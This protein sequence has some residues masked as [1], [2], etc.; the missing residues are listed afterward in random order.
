[1]KIVPEGIRSLKS[2]K[3]IKFDLPTTD[4]KYRK[5]TTLSGEE[6]NSPF[7]RRNLPKKSS[8]LNNFDM[9]H[10]EK[11]SDFNKSLMKIQNSDSKK[12]FEDKRKSLNLDFPLKK[13]ENK[14]YLKYGTLSKAKIQTEENR[15]RDNNS[16]LIKLHSSILNKKKSKFFNDDNKKKKMSID[17]SC[18]SDSDLEEKNLRE[19]LK[20]KETLRK[21][22]SRVNTRRLSNLTTTEEEQKFTRVYFFLIFLQYKFYN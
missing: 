12:N 15:K 21:T 9:I 19:G 18:D 10:F 17:N 4:I 8:T 6:K 16:N 11:I 5:N 3:S 20:K 1:M 2:N 22:L 14:E 13:N 7:K